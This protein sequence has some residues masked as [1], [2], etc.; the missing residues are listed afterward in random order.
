MKKIIKKLLLLFVLFVAVKTL[1][2]YFIPSP[3]AFSDEYLYARMARNLLYNGSLSVHGMLSP[4]ISPLYP[5]LISI[6]YIFKNMEIVFFIIKFLNAIFSSL[7]IFPSWLLA[8]G[9]LSSRKALHISILVSLMPSIFAFTPYVMG[10]NLFYTLFL[11]SIYF[12]Y[13]SLYRG[14]VYSILAG[15]FIGATYLTRITGIILLPIAGL[16]FLIKILK[17]DY[18]LIKKGALMLGAS[19]I[20]IF[21]WLLRNKLLFGFKLTNLFGYYSREIGLLAVPEYSALALIT[22]FSYH[23]GLVL[24]ATGILPLLYMLIN[25]KK[26]DQPSR[27]LIIISLSATVLFAL[28]ASHHCNHCV[29]NLTS[30]FFW[31]TSRPFERYLNVI[32]PLVLISGLVSF[33][34]KLS[35]KLIIPTSLILAFSSILTIF[36]LFPSNNLSLTWLGVLK[37][38]I[39]SLLY[40]QVIFESL[41]ISSLVI[42]AIILGLI[43]YLLYLLIRKINFNKFLVLLGIFFLF[44]SLLA[45]GATYYNSSKFWYEGEQMQLGLEFNKYDIEKNILID[46]RDCGTKLTKTDQSSLCTKWFT[47]IGFWLNDNLLIGDVNQSGKTDYIITKHN[48]EL[49]KVMETDSGIKIYSTS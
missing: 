15:L 43:P 16:I 33:N 40:K 41:T 42:F 47:I 49:N 35:L 48:L 17:K 6:A 31:I 11:F 30:N 18:S 32:F 10:E 19:L 36:P 37:Y 34:K 2:S 39:D 23:I 45:Y 12:I 9:F 5:S 14:Y 8:K 7:I 20:T 3:S 4:Q 26:K 28:A 44:T 29:N 38:A 21:P 24:L 27:D 13:K 22:R 46:E 25:F 1:L